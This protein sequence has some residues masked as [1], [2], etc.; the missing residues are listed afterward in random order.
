[1]R[2]VL[3]LDPFDSI[4]MVKVVLNTVDCQAAKEHVEVDIPYETRCIKASKTKEELHLP[5][6]ILP[7]TY[8]LNKIRALTKLDIEGSYKNLILHIFN[9]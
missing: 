4:F 8:H 5:C 7:H 2:Y 1:M 3:T 9:L 6:F